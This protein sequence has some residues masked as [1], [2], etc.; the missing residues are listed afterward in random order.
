MARNPEKFFKFRKTLEDESAKIY[1]VTLRGTKEQTDAKS[2]FEQKLREKLDG[3]EDILTVMLPKFA[4]GCR[5]LTPGPGYLE[6][7]KKDN[8]EFISMSIDEITNN[9]INL[10]SGEKIELDVIV[11]A[12]GYDVEAP[13]QFKVIGRNGITLADR[14]KPQIETYLALAVDQFPNF[15]MIGG[16]GSGLGSGSLV[17]VF[18]AQGGY[19]VKAI[20]KMQKE[21]YATMEVKPER[22]ADFSQHIEEYFK[23]TVYTDNCSSWYKNGKTG[24]RITALWPGSSMQCLEV[25]RSPRWEDYIFESA[26]P[27]GNHLRWI[28]NG[29]STVL[30]DGDPSWFL[31]DDVV[32]MPEEGKPEEGEKYHRRPFTY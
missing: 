3:R 15:L 17:S 20:R 24:A 12:T 21:D 29:W 32:D 6:A 22:V 4:P 19:A 11:C 31:D 8:V 18:E 1:P 2:L 26:D 5:R 25:L 30:Y 16:P 13:P 9:G 14:W 28:G 10:T 23:K 27:T 7:L